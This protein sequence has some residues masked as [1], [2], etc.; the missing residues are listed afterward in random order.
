M[1]TRFAVVSSVAEAVELCLFDE[2]GG[3]RRVELPERSGDVWHAELPDVQPGQRYGYRVH[4]P[5]EPQAGHRFN[6]A[7]LL[8][9]PYALAIDGLVDEAAANVLPYP[10]GEADADLQIDDEDSAPAVPKSVV[11]DPGFDWEDDRA[12]GTPLD[13]SVIY[14]VHVKDLTKRHPDVREDL[15]VIARERG[16]DVTPR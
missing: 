3:E 1:G 14:E 10:P 9:D 13:R 5:W 2:D 12:P 15:R 4:G 8:I 7:K 16:Q 6:P 11:I